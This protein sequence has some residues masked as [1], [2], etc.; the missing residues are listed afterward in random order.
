MGYTVLHAR[1]CSPGSPCLPELSIGSWL[2]S[3][4]TSAF[5]TASLHQQ[6]CEDTN[7]QQHQ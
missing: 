2:Y 4:H 3:S 5:L 6:P 1:G 7:D